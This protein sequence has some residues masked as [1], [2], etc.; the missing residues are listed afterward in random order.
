MNL[1]RSTR[2]IIAALFATTLGACGT[3]GP[4]SDSTQSPTSGSPSFSTEA[5]T[6][7]EAM[8]MLGITGILSDID[9]EAPADSPEL[10]PGALA[11]TFGGQSLPQP[12]VKVRRARLRSGGRLSEVNVVYG[13]DRAWARHMLVVDAQPIMCTSKAVHPEARDHAEMLMDADVDELTRFIFDRETSR[14]VVNKTDPSAIPSVA[15]QRQH[16]AECQALAAALA[17]LN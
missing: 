10:A 2:P 5:S 11:T 14:W 13:D 7:D 12:I 1:A 15:V 8:S 17:R 6:P 9:P 4:P 3:S 16:F